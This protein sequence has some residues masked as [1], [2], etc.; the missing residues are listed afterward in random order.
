MIPRPIKI[1][2]PRVFESLR[3]VTDDGHQTAVLQHTSVYGAQRKQL[4]KFPDYI[5]LPTDL[6]QEFIQEENHNSGEG[7]FECASSATFRSCIP[8]TG[9][10]ISESFC[11]DDDDELKIYPRVR[12]VSVFS[13][14][15]RG[16]NVCN[17]KTPESPKSLP[18]DQLLNTLAS[19]REQWSATEASKQYGK[20]G[21]GDQYDL[22]VSTE[23]VNQSSER[24]DK[25]AVQPGERSKADQYEFITDYDQGIELS[26]NGS[27]ELPFYNF[28]R[29]NMRQ[30]FEVQDDLNTGSKR[31]RLLR[32]SLYEEQNAK[33]KAKVKTLSPMISEDE[34]E[35]KSNCLK[36]KLEGESVPSFLH[37]E[38]E[39]KTL[40]LG[41]SEHKTESKVSSFQTHQKSE[42]EVESVSS[43]V[44]PEI[45]IKTQTRAISEHETESKVPGFQIRQKSELEFRSVSSFVCPEIELKTP[46]QVISEH[47]TEIKLPGSQSRQKY[48]LEVESVSSFGC[49]ETELTPAQVILKHETED[50]VPDFQTSQKLEMQGKS[51]SSF[52][53]LETELKPPTQAISKHEN[54]SKVPGFQ[55]SQKS[56]M[57][58]E[59]DS[60]FLCPQ[61][62]LKPRTPAISEHETEI[63]IP[64]FQTQRKSKFEGESVEANAV[65]SVLGSEDY[66]PLD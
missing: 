24:Q 25:F 35:N 17:P 66:I 23:L 59:S 47:K 45:E 49:P 2:E 37:P 31:R 28:P 65:T 64:G 44:H 39:L 52:L 53:C 12:R 43:F 3:V 9:K 29:R 55:T 60:S 32:P 10:E 11:M 26:E 15:S 16:Q 22:T 5:P 51:V 58:G 63:Q 8:S 38:T 19:R 27:F 6:Q 54:E 56:E 41:I 42:L 18:L 21:G 33:G 1:Q 13:R 61:T 40:T 14:L 7:N 57:Q 30:K 4:F 50:K 36:S 46:T 62:E 48:E 20:R 34:K